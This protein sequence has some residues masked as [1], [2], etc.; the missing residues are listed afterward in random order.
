[1]H[2]TLKYCVY[3]KKR[4]RRL[5]HS[6][7]LIT[8]FFENLHT[9]YT[10]YLEKPTAT[11][12]TSKIFKNH[13]KSETELE[14]FKIEQNSLGI[15]VIDSK[16]KAEYQ[17]ILAVPKA[18]EC[19]LA[20]GYCGFCVHNFRCSC[21]NNRFHGDFCIHLHLLSS[22]RHLLPPFELPINAQIAFFAKAGKYSN[23]FILTDNLAI[24]SQHQT[25]QTHIAVETIHKVESLQRSSEVS[26][27]IDNHSNSTIDNAIEYPDDFDNDCLDDELDNDRLG[28]KLQPLCPSNEE[29]FEFA[30]QN[31]SNL[32]STFGH[33]IQKLR[34]PSHLPT[35]SDI[36]TVKDIY[37]R[38][39][40]ELPNFSAMCGPIVLEN[41]Q[42]SSQKRKLSEEDKQIRLVSNDKSKPGR[43]KSKKVLK[44]PDS[45]EKRKLE[46]ELIDGPPAKKKSTKKLDFK[47]STSAPT[48]STS[49]QASKSSGHT[50]PKQSK[51]NSKKS[52]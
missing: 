43:K 52:Q 26:L 17:I 15:I 47:K 35:E 48:K 41:C 2:K 51:T 14:H 3:E 19:Y 20:C 21:N 12:K 33:Y 42:T 40:K 36:S 22:F 49:K 31:L 7:H 39:C 10:L 44:K 9:D 16:K 37:S 25:D 4:I 38:W 6:I 1:M 13:L 50:K 23:F 11:P 5:D 29:Q 18:H 32:H 28:K 34:K 30:I 46:K 8:Q 27:S 45:P 24:T